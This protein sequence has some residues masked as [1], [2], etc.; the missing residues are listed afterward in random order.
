MK[1]KKK[2]LSVFILLL[3]LFSV[4]RF[5][6]SVLG[7]DYKR[8]QS[9]SFNQN[10]NFEYRAKTHTMKHGYLIVDPTEVIYTTSEGLPVWKKAFSSQNVGSAVGSNWMVLCEQKAGDVFVLD[11]KGN[12]TAEKLNLGPIEHIK[13]LNDQFVAVLLRNRE[14]LLF[15]AKMAL[16]SNTTLPK[17]KLIDF[18]LTPNHSEIVVGLLDL[19]RKDFNTKLVFTDRLGNI[20]SGSHIYE[21]IAYDIVLRP[22]NIIMVVDSGFLFYNYKGALQNVADIDRTIGQ[23]LFH[24]KN[25]EIWVYLINEQPD[26]E[27]PKPPFEILVLDENG[28]HL[29]AFEPPIESVKGMV[30]FG[31]NAIFYNL[32]E[33]AIVSKEGKV[34]GRYVINEEIAGVHAVDQKS[35]AI[36]LVNRLDI[37]IRK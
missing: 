6:F 14:L 30:A 4:M 10:N 18:A 26:L 28:G 23:F 19:S 27:N 35:F 9:H 25:K 17:G 36:E 2:R 16:L 20:T 21:A 8:V 32:N 11:V 5:N 3:C 33:V 15:D 12:V 1:P 34:E 22:Q 31:E 29:R 24:D 7:D 13:I 37:Y